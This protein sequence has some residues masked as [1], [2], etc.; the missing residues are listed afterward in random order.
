[1]VATGN[2]LIKPKKE[3]A[4]GDRGDY[5]TEKKSATLTGNVKLTRG[6]NQLNGNK[7]IVNMATG[8]SRMVGKVTILMIPREGEGG[9][10]L[11]G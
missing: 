9:I 6:D 1:M 5:N 3:I 2:V 4:R 8:V 10:G 11:P 7:A